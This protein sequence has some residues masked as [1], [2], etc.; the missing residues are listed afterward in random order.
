MDNPSTPEKSRLETLRDEGV[1]RGIEGARTMTI[2]QIERAL[3]SGSKESTTPVAS[4]APKGATKPK[5]PSIG[6]VRKADAERK[7]DAWLAENPDRVSDLDLSIPGVGGRQTAKR[8]HA[9]D[10]AVATMRANG[11]LG[12]ASAKEPVDPVLSARAKQAWE[13]RRAH[14][15]A[16]EAEQA[17]QSG[18]TETGT[19]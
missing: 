9:A 4:D 19:E 2:K 3:A 15:A 18:E 11:T 12:E 8:R 17:A 1:E 6:S 16:W 5:A 7:F 14:V 10:K 13:T